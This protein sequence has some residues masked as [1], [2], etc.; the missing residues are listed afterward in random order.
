MPLDRRGI[1]QGGALLDLGYHGVAPQSHW[2]DLRSQLPMLYRVTVGLC[3]LI[4]ATAAVYAGVRMNIAAGFFV[5]VAQTIV[6]SVLA[7]YAY[8]CRRYRVASSVVLGA[9][10]LSGALTWAFVQQ[11]AYEAHP[12][13][14][15]VWSMLALGAQGVVAIFGGYLGYACMEA[16][17]LRPSNPGHA[18]GKLV[19]AGIVG[20][21]LIVSEA[22]V[23]TGMAM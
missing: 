17:R 6:F 8:A 16:E 2:H 21:A 23:A 10:C 4:A 13:G 15:A 12:M 1:T 5:A 3:G 9:V 22:L 7:A 11:F 14:M 18:S 20:M 19:V